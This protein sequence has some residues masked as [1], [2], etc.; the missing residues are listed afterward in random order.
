M[1]KIKKITLLCLSLLACFSLATAVACD[2]NSSMESNTS[3][4]SSNS[5]SVDET[6]SD[7]ESTEDSS[8]ESE[9]TYVYRVAIQHPSGFGLRDTRVKLMDG[10]K[11]VASAT[12]NSS[13]YAYF[14]NGED[15]VELGRYDVVIDELPAGYAYMNEGETYQ[16]VAVPGTEVT[17]P[18]MPTGVMQGELPAGNVYRLGDVMYDFT[19]TLSDGS[20]FTLS[21]VLQEKELVVINFWATW[22]GPCKSEF[23][24]MNTALLQY[25]NV[26]CIAIS[27][28]DSKDAVASFKN[29]NNL[30]FNMAGQGA[31]N[32]LAEKFA[33][34]F[35]VPNTDEIDIWVTEQQ[36]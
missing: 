13:G 31:G 22:C 17:I 30:S 14:R 3:T 29:S 16:T 35:E 27:T 21:N 26:D 2:G 20:T 32:N 9:L 1:K 4:E 36:K 15:A 18:L 24:M 12:T 7:E 11:V 10:D 19:A 34:I 28:T 6:S 8:P 23:P 5:E 33:S 25:S